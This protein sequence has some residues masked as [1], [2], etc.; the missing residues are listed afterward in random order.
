[1]K[2]DTISPVFVAHPLKTGDNI[3]FYNK[4]GVLI[5]ALA[6]KGIN[7]ERKP[8]GRK[9][10]YGSFGGKLYYGWNGKA[11]SLS[12]SFKDVSIGAE[13]NIRLPF[14]SLY[15]FMLCDR[16]ISK[17][18]YSIKSWYDLAFSSMD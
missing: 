6:W 15:F 16:E 11:R 12:L 7:V 5:R 10:G 4:S 14:P 13:Y 8:L 18:G 3:T 2:R 1:M 9:V 17:K